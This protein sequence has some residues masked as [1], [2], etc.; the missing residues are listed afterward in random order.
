MRRRGRLRLCSGHLV[1]EV[2]GVDQLVLL[3]LRAQQ[4]R[5]ECV[6]RVRQVLVEV[7]PREEA[8]EVGVA[9]VGEVEGVRREVVAALRPKVGRVVL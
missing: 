2:G 7:C 5:I 1:H 3:R 8:V 9:V 4:L 6:A